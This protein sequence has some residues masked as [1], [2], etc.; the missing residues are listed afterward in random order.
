M[1]K[2]I[3]AGF[4]SVVFM[5]FGQVFIN[6]QIIKGLVLMIIEVL[7]LLRF[8]YFYS[9]ISGLITLGTITGF[10]QENIR[11]NDHSIFLMIEGWIA[12]ILIAV[13]LSIYVANVL[14]AIKIAKKYQLVKERETSKQFLRRITHKL[15]PYTMSL[16]SISLIVF[17]I[18]MPILFTASIAFTNYSS[19][20]HLPPANL[21]DWVGLQNIMDIF[22]VP[23]WR[24]TFL[25]VFIWT[26]LWA[27]FSTFFAYAAGLGV[28]LL[29]NSNFV[30]LK[31]IWR[32]IY[33]LPYAIPA[34][35]SL[36]I[37]K[38]LLN[39]QFGPI[40]LALKEIGVIDTYFGVFKNNI[41][42]LSNPN[43]ARVSVVVVSV[44]LAFPYFMALMT[45]IMTSISKTLYE[46]AE[47]DGANKFQQFRTITL[48]M[49]LTATMPIIIMSFAYNFNSFTNI[50]FLTEGGPVGSYSTGSFAGSTDIL[51]TWI[52]NLNFKSNNY[53]MASLM[54]LTIFI[55]IGGFSILFFSRTKAFKEL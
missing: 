5:W 54:S 42:W 43:L 20:D 26:V 53:A 52:Y 18:L 2:P 8:N 46:A 29:V 12:V 17:F 10:S 41:G 13:Y 32:T 6:R 1:E 55:V 44:W 33:I 31:K 28:A 38:N 11:Y 23:M 37:F 7:A 48:P 47:I 30:K 39:G 51:I 19:P 14:D 16:P 34:M 3:K 21:V 4:L 25:G 40:N 49:V 15:F 9:A 22:S 24:D 50:Y 45:G 27:I 36:L 35:I